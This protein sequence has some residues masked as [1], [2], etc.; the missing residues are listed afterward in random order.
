[1]A[2][3]FELTTPRQMLEKAKREFQRLAKNIDSDKIFNFFVTAYH[4]YD[5]VKGD[6][7]VPEKDIND[8]RSNP[9]FK[10]CKYICNKNK[11]RTL[12]KGDDEFITYRRPGAVFGEA[13]F[14]ES[15]F[16]GKRAYFIIE[17]NEQVDVLELG[18]KII[19]LWETFL[20]EH[21]I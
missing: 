21:N 1:M 4:V 9:D 5:Y 10:K 14:G 12:R 2:E 6:D 3:F 15:L 19:N 13:V 8:I 11:H 20:N 16:N 18:Q 17:K 7:T